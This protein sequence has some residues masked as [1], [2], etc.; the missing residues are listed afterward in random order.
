MLAVIHNCRSISD[1]LAVHV[2]EAAECFSAVPSIAQPLPAA[3][4]K[5]RRS[6]TAKFP[7]AFCRLQEG[8]AI[9]PRA[10]YAGELPARG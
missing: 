5:A 6:R 9:R 10:R 4:L 7:R 2:E 8:R 3:I 1:A